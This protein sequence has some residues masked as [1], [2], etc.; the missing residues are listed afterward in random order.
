MSGVIAVWMSCYN[1]QDTVAESINSVLCQ[2]YEDFVFYIIDD[3]STDGT[4][5]I[6]QMYAEQDRRVRFIR[7]E[8]NRGLPAALNSLAKISQ[9]PFVARQDADDISAP[10]RIKVM[11]DFLI[12]QPAVAACF[13]RTRCF[14]D[15]GNE[16][17]TRGLMLRFLG[18]RISLLF[19]NP[20]CHGSAV[21]RRS[22]YDQVGGYD[23]NYLFAQDYAFW[24]QLAVNGLRL[25]LIPKCLYGY[26]NLIKSERKQR[27]QRK[28]FQIIRRRY[29]LNCLGLDCIA[30]LFGS[31]RA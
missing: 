22:A 23:E 13:S 26:R 27:A 11:L 31:N 6:V 7:N 28:L 9:E 14:D 29:W 15:R 18:P 5:A 25:E 17:M 3:G 21:F 2:S 4:C 20:F 10:D 8:V 30:R 16:K 1:A 19:T 24:T 12:R